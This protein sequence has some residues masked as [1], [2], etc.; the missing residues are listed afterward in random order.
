VLASIGGV[1]PML[2]S[3]F[4][5]C[6]NLGLTSGQLQQFVGIIS[7]AIGTEEAK[8]ARAVLN[9]VLKSRK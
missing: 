9:E 2:R 6:V 1:E 7:Q 4:G 3:H 5:I 8:A